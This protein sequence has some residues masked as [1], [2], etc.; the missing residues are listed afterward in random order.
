MLGEHRSA[1]A[2]GAGMS[3]KTLLVG[4]SQFLVERVK[5]ECVELI[6]LHTVVGFTWHHI[7]CL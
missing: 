1:L 7:T 2:A 3:A 5:Q 6:A 4:R